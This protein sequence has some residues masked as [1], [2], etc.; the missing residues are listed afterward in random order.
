[1]FLQSKILA[2]KIYI[3]TDLEGTS[4][5][6]KWAQIDNKDDRLNLEACEF[7]MKDLQ[8]VIR[9]LQAGG[10]KEIMVFD[11]HGLQSVLPGMMIP[12]AKYLTG[13]PRPVG[14]L[15]FDSTYDGVVLLGF[16]AMMGVEDGVL[17]HTQNPENGARYWYNGVESGEIAQDAAKCGFFGVPVIMVTGDIATCREATKFLGGGCVTVAVKEGIARESAVLYPLEETSMALYEGAKNSIAA[18]PKCKPYVLKIPIK[19]KKIYYSKSELDPRFP[20]PKLT[21]VEWIIKGEPDFL[22]Y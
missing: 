8:A 9:G 3:I 5:V 1:V 17:N 16:H 7:F 14:L 4:G 10:A 21:T 18:I 15:K 13:H 2:Q 11:A 22:E 12:G 6:Y 19:A 20:I